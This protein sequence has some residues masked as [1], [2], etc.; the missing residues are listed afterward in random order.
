MSVLSEPQQ[1]DQELKRNKHKILEKNNQN[2]QK[3]PSTNLKNT[4][5]KQMKF[6]S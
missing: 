5:A 2:Q 1:E 3:I 4:F 6:R